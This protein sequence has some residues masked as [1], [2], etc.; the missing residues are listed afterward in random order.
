[1]RERER[2][3]ERDVSSVSHLSDESHYASMWVRHRYKFYLG[4]QYLKGIHWLKR[5]P[6]S[7]INL[8]F[9]HYIY[10]LS[11]CAL[12]LVTVVKSSLFAGT[13]NITA[14]IN[15]ATYGLT[16]A[17]IS[18][19][20]LIFSGSNETDSVSCFP[21][22]T[23]TDFEIVSAKLP[24]PI[25]VYHTMVLDIIFTFNANTIQLLPSFLN[26]QYLPMKLEGVGF[27][28]R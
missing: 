9:H 5:A 13:A 1:M 26:Q 8:F 28:R 4:E 25:L 16:T 3:S 7:S 27:Q 17:L 23:T 22:G 6:M 21:L 15:D 12:F 20:S 24:T 19:A 10:I 18:S 2:E 14:S 11:F